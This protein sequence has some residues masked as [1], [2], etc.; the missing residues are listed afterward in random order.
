MDR[1]GTGHREGIERSIDGGQGQGNGAGHRWCMDK[2][3]TV[4][5]KGFDNYRK[6]SAPACGWRPNI[7]EWGVPSPPLAIL[8]LFIATEILRCPHWVA[9]GKILF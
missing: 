4:I 3:W 2:A 5:P 1:T 8:K 7:G 6:Q 9:K